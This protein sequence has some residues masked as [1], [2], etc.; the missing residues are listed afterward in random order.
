MTVEIK[1]LAGE[2]IHIH[3]GDML[4]DA[5]L[6]GADLSDADLSGAN[7][8]GANLRDASLS[9]ADLRGANLRYAS[10]HDADLYGVKVDEKTT[11]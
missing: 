5:D 1:N 2:V 11:F 8:Y 6:Y 10:L 7:L 9:D 3:D 4:S